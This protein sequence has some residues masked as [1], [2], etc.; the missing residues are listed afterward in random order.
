MS[1]D[2]GHLINAEGIAHFLSRSEIHTL[3]T[4]NSAAFEEVQASLKDQSFPITRAWSSGSSIAEVKAVAKALRGKYDNVLLIGIGGSTLGF[5]STLQ[6]LKGPFYNLQDS[7]RRGPRMFVLDNVDPVVAEQLAALLDFRKTALVYISK[8]GSTPEPA[9]NFIYFIKKYKDAEG[10]P[11][12]IVVICD[13]KDN[14]I[15]HMAK[16]LGCHLL[17]IPIDLPG[18]Y[19]VLSPAGLLPAELVA[20]DANRLVEGAVEVHD[21]IVRRPADENAVFILGTALAALA[22]K[23]KSIH[24]LFNYGNAL[25]EFGLWFEQ[26]WAESLG[27]ET[28]ITGQIVHSGTTPLSALGATDQHSVLQLFKEGPNDKVFGFVTIENWPPSIRLT[29]EFPSEVEYAYFAGHA[30]DEQLRIEQLSTEMSLVKARRPCYRVILRD[31]SAPAIGGIF[32]FMEAL[33]VFMAKI[34]QVDPFNQ[35]GVEEGKSMTYALMGR[36]DYIPK[37]HEY[38]QALEVFEKQSYKLTL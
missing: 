10:D 20:V 13:K 21:A 7:S 27:K 32:Y 38:E 6:F 15:N 11:G 37:R 25:S 9:A 18:R 19:G 22:D 31:I 3:A 23:G 26:L 4:K 14:G 30:L 1:V 12:D 28:S 8:S 24:V 17:H 5:R 34:W 36:A 16:G 29:N 35:P 2:V 33:T